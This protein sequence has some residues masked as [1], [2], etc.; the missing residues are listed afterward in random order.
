M[1]YPEQIRIYENLANRF[2]AR[3]IL[4]VGCGV[5]TGAALLSFHNRVI[6]TD[7]YNRNLTFVKR[8]YPWLNLE[9]YDVTESPIDNKVDT[10]V[11]VE[12]IEHLKD[13]ETAMRNMIHSATLEVWL[14]T[15]N[16]RHPDLRDNQPLNR[17]HVR[18]FYPEEILEM[19][20]RHGVK[21]IDILNW[22]D[23]APLK[24]E[25]KISPLVYRIRV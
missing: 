22:Q 24:P 23:F 15:P 1:T 13:Y 18:E 20:S 4:E 8:L 6:A 3:T 11:A 25:T 12:V 5:G 10:I 19:A 16:R 9:I 21:D 7:K 2:K 14:S 17:H